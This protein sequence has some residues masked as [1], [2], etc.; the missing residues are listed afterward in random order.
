MRVKA[1]IFLMV[2][3]GGLISG[4]KKDSGGEVTPEMIAEGQ[5]IF[6]QKCVS[7]HTVGQGARVGPDL[8]D[9]TT[10]R[11]QDWLARWIKDPTGMSQSD[12]EAQKLVAEWKKGGLMPPLLT[13]EDEIKSVIAYLKD[14]SAKAK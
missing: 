8:K 5:T 11:Q 4:C 7:C 6:E 1:S 14:A 12:P 10:R 3:L 2:A 9:V 13:D